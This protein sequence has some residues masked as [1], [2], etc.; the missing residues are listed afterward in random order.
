MT[1]QLHSTVTQ[2]TT[3]EHSAFCTARSR[4]EGFDRGALFT[5]RNGLEMLLAGL[6]ALYE[7]GNMEA[8]DHALRDAL[9]HTLHAAVTAR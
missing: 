9:V 8:P 5:T 3:I 4:N 6:T 2:Y 1:H 7:R